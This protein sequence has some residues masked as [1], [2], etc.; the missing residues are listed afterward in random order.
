MCSIY[1]KQKI[2][3]K[4]MNPIIN[5]DNSSINIFNLVDLMKNLIINETSVCQCGYH[6][7]KI[8]N[9]NDKN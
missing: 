8:I 9:E 2:R 5:F 3:E 1:I 6:N 4:F 7:G